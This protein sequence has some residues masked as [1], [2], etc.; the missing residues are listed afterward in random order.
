MLW[1]RQG[2]PKYFEILKCSVPI[3]WV[4]TTLFQ[5]FQLSFVQLFPLES[6]PKKLS[7]NLRTSM[8]TPGWVNGRPGIPEGYVEES[9]RGKK[10]KEKKKV[11]HRP[12]WPVETRKTGPHPPLKLNSPTWVHS[13]RAVETLLLLPL[14]LDPLTIFI[15]PVDW[16]WLE[17]PR[18]DIHGPP[19]GMGPP[20]WPD[21]YVRQ[22]ELASSIYRQPPLPAGD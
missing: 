17:R 22:L 6:S 4:I 21:P 14:N 20:P 3:F 1:N 11:A 19:P 8:R 2:F 12:G 9:A 16:G 10:K 7:K 5:L 13:A 18:G 15:F